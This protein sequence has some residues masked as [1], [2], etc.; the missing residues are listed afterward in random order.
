[1]KKWLIALVLLILC[2][3]AAMA[4][5]TACIDGGTADRVH[6][7]QSPS[8]EASSLGLY[9]TGAPVERLADLSGGWS[10]VRIGTQTGY[11]RTQYL[12][13]AAEAAFPARVVNNP[14]SD[15]VNLRSGASFD[16][17]PVGRLNNGDIL[18]LI[19]ETASGWSYVEADDLHG[20]VVTEFLAQWQDT[21]GV[22]T[23]RASAAAQTQIVGTTAD[24]S[25]IH[26]CTTGEG[27]TLYFVAQEPDPVITREDVNF[28]GYAD[29]VVTTARGATNCYYAFF[30][31]NGGGYVRAAHPGVEGI[32]NYGLYP[33]QGY[34]LS[35]ANHG[36]AGALYEDCLMCWEG[37]DLH[38]IRS[39][40]A[41]SL[42]EYRTE[43]NAL[44]TVLHDRKIEMNVYGGSV[45]GEAV[46]LHSEVI[47][48]NDMDAEKLMEMKEA[49]W[50]GLR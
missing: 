16:D 48:L 11:V 44:V 40:T 9:F 45:D 22:G 29:L 8:E 18:R 20:Y 6:L 4:A 17:A 41:R 5:E 39:A 25:Y 28:D 30:V 12:T 32:A 42:R 31:W 46:L 26:A 27:Q 50:R 15:W 21:L 37:T 14:T 36:Y 7:R 47:D 10:R 2:L 24:G 3:Q 38:L 1:M 23:P 34:V 33:D 35:S 13:A 49:L 19:G 43:G